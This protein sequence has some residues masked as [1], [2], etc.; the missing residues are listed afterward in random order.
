MCLPKLID[1]KV[2]TRPNSVG[3][4]PIR[5]LP[6]SSISSKVSICPNSDGN[7]PD[8]LFEPK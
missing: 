2:L 8:N 3:I 5:I 1:F 4:D 6:L 7:D